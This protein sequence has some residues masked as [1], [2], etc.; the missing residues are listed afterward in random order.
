M[1]CSFAVLLRTANEMN[2]HLKHSFAK[3]KQDLNVH[4]V[5]SSHPYR[6]T[7]LSSKATHFSPNYQITAINK[8]ECVYIKAQDSCEVLCSQTGQNMTRWARVTPSIFYLYRGLWVAASNPCRSQVRDSIYY[9]WA[10]HVSPI[11][12]IRRIFVPANVS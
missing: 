4:V 9:N 8:M 1:H 3:W 10:N 2:R 5:I 12:E 7:K 6:Q 11:I